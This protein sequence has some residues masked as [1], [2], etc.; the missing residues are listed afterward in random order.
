[1]AHFCALM[2]AFLHKSSSNLSVNFA[3][4]LGLQ[5]PPLALQPAKQSPGNCDAETFE[6]TTN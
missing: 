1:M 2:S 4:E 3:L 5:P 6:Q